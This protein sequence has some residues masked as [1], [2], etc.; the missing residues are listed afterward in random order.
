MKFSLGI[1]TAAMALAASTNSFAGDFSFSG[2]IVN[3]KDVVRINFT[4]G[5]AGPVTIFTDSWLA[6]L[7]F[8]P[9]LWLWDDTGLAINSKFNQDIGSDNL[10][11]KLELNTLGAGNYHLALFAFNNFPAGLGDV[12]DGFTYDNTTPQALAGFVADNCGDGFDFPACSN[13]QKG[14][15]T[16]WSV[17]LQ[18]VDSASLV[19]EPDTYALFGAGLGVLAWIGGRRRKTNIANMARGS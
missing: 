6:D 9:S 7:N 1:C 16:H 2:D 3:Q 13:P 12:A 8:D 18:G 14:T 11:A 10:D 5:T 4:L 17:K 19:P 15:G